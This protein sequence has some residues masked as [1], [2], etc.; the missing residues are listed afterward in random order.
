[1]RWFLVLAALCLNGRASLARW[2]GPQDNKARPL[3]ETM[4]AKE[5]FE[6][7]FDV[8][9]RRAQLAALTPGPEEGAVLLAAEEYLAT[10]E[11]VVREAHGG[12]LPQWMRSLSFARTTRDCQ[13]VFR[14]FLGGETAPETKPAGE[15]VRAGPEPATQGKSA[16]TPSRTR[17][18]AGK[19]GAV[20]TRTATPVIRVPP[21][22]I[23]WFSPTA[24][25][26]S[27][28]EKP[29]PSPR[30]TLTP[31]RSPVSQK[32]PPTR[33]PKREAP[34]VTDELPPWFQ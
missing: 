33:A 28:S 14:S 13:A 12:R 30:P 16:R 17:R 26:R 11:D 10:I 9:V 32:P 5:L 6:E 3:L 31:R 19:V 24:A 25:P 22:P 29:S 7:A 23:L 34:E 21:F 4:G 8:C 15:E 2:V 18:E 20:R 1:M 27:L